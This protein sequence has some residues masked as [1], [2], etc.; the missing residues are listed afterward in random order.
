MFTNMSA[1]CEISVMANS[2]IFLVTLAGFS[3]H[4]F[5]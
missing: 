2:G 3:T 5:S 4:F 1:V